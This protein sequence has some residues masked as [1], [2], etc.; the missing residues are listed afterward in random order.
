[1]ETRELI[2]AMT[3]FVAIVAVVALIT[4][5]IGKAISNKTV[6]E[7]LRASPETVALVNQRLMA[8]RRWRPEAVGLLVMA[9]GAALAGAALIGPVEQRVVLLQ[10]ALLP[11]FVGA[12]LVGLRWLP[13]NR[14]GPAESL[15]DQQAE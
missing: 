2:I 6:R 13:A 4:G 14:D 12:A 7:A 15:T 11:G 10:L 5:V 1:M 8:R 9:L 3:V